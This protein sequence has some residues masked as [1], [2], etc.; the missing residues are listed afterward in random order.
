MKFAIP[1][2]YPTDENLRILELFDFPIDVIIPTPTIKEFEEMEKEIKQSNPK[3]DRVGYWPLFQDSIYWLSTWQFLQCSTHE[4][5]IRIRH[6]GMCNRNTKS[7][8]YA[9]G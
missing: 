7:T 3:I 1:E 2:E 5:T 4:G 6:T 9:L 8:G